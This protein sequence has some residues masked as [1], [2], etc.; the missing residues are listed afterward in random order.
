[1][2]NVDLFSVLVAGLLGAAFLT[3]ITLV[4][5]AGSAQPAAYGRTLGTGFA[6]GA[7]VQLSVRLLGVS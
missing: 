1:M 7:G 4:L 5:G 2:K 3:A 6:V